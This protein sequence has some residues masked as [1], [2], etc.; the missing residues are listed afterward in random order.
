VPMDLNQGLQDRAINTLPA[1]L[2]LA[3]RLLI[4]ESMRQQGPPSPSFRC[5]PSSSAAW[6][7]ARSSLRLVEDLESVV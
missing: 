1:R 5:M 6:A 2:P 4:G 7:L 3:E